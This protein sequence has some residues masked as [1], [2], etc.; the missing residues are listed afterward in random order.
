[1]FHERDMTRIS[2]RL[3]SDESGFTLIKLLTSMAIGMILLF[4]AFMLLDR[5]TALTKQITDRQ[6]AV[7]RGRQAMELMVR[8]FAR[9]SASATRPSR[10][11]SHRTT[12]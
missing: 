1:M 11:R 4:A 8:T 9:R 6:D 10:S 12:A 2:R 5:S 7:Q 3:R